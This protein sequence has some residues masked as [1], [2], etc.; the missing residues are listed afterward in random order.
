[1]SPEALERL[2]KDIKPLSTEDAVGSKVCQNP[3]PWHI[4]AILLVQWAILAS[5][6]PSSISQEYLLTKIKFAVAVGFLS[7]GVCLVTTSPSILH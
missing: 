4:K 7:T 6:F 3:E 5:R 1:M 2:T